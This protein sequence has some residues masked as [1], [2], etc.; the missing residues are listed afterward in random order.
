MIC[1]EYTTNTF[2]GTDSRPGFEIN[3]NLIS[4]K[5]NVLTEKVNTVF[6]HYRVK[7]RGLPI[8]IPGPLTSRLGIGG[9]A[10]AVRAS[11]AWARSGRLAVAADE[12]T[13]DN[14]SYTIK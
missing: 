14:V 1:R 11:E 5:C 2:R 8:P 13:C 7:T 3:I 9:V 6:R 10:K 4:G 12:S